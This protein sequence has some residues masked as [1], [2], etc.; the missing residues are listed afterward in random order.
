M[1]EL[2]A[3]HGAKNW[4][5]IGSHMPGRVGKQCRERCGRHSA[6]CIAVAT[7]TAAA[8]ATRSRRFSSFVRCWCFCA[9][10]LHKID[11]LLSAVR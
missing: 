6:V 4:P 11:G 1:L 3:V 8:T 9:V 2:V 5:I 7:T 10:Q